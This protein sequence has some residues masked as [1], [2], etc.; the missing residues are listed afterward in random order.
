MTH[1]RVPAIL[2]VCL[3]NIC[4][5]P[6]AEAAFRQE[7]G[8]AGLDIHAESAGTGDYHIGAAPDPRSIAEAAKHG[9]DIT[10][11]KGAQLQRDDFDRFTHIFAMDHANLAEIRALAPQGSSTEIALLMDNV[12]GREGAAIA[13]PYHDGEEHFADTWE[14]VSAAAKALVRKLS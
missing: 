11:Y 7:A 2:F 1:S 3:G 12:A 9:V 6:L 8:K 4:R 13:D 14:D 10:Y 5:S